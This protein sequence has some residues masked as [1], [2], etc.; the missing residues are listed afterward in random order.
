MQRN[1]NLP[2]LRFCPFCQYCTF[3]GLEFR[4]RCQ[5]LEKILSHTF[6]FLQLMAVS[7]FMSLWRHCICHLWQNKPTQNFLGRV[8][9]I[10]GIFRLELFLKID[11]IQNDYP[12][13]PD[14]FSVDL[15]IE[16]SA[17]FFA[18]VPRSFFV[19]LINSWKVIYKGS[20]NIWKFIRIFLNVDIAEKF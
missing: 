3:F 20:I 18:I 19:C 11:L 14:V 10:F 6:I 12:L 5:F 17:C 2:S 1:R 9:T 7:T 8:F 16:F 4:Q 13:F 15:S